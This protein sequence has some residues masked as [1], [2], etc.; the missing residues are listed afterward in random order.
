MPRTSHI[1][2]AASNL[3]GISL[4][5]ITGLHIAHHTRQRIVDEMAWAGAL[6]FALA[7]LF[8]YLDLRA[9]PADTPHEKRADWLFMVGLLMM[10]VSVLVLAISDW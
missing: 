10:S 7:C 5:I 6:C 4:L 3:L 9:E 1:L 8:S 2:N